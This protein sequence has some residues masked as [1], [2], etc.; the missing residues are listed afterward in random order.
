MSGIFP[1][2]Q[3][4]RL[5]L[6]ELTDQDADVLYAMHTDHADMQRYGSDRMTRREDASELIAQFAGLR[7]NPCSGIQWGISLRESTTLLG[8]CG[9]QK[10]NR[11]WHSCAVCYDLK[12]SARGHGYMQ[13]ALRS[14]I[15]WAFANMN[16]NRIEACIYPGS[17][18]SIMLAEKL[19][20]ARE[21]VLRKAGYWDE[22]YH[23]MRI[24]GLLKNEFY[25]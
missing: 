16:L 7:Q 14:A 6:R 13:E 15:A 3:T 17:R 2:L 23:D 20:F 11:D 12:V 21:G 18:A 9:F 8:T 4:P 22:Q 1:E 10:W 5:L 19:G 24:Y 25:G